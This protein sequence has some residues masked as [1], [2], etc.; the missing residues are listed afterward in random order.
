MRF[1]ATHTAPDGQIHYIDFSLKPVTDAEGRV[2]QL[3]PEGRDI[4]ERKRAEEEI[5]KLNQELEQRVAE[6]TAQLEAAN[7]ELEAFAYSVSHDLRAPLRAHRR[8]SRAAQEEDWRRRSTSRAGTTWHDHRDVGQA[9]GD[10]DRRPA[11]LL[12]HGART[13][14]PSA[15]RPERPGARR[16]SG[17]CEPETRGRTVHWRIGELPVVSGDRAMLRVVL[18]NLISNALKFTQPRAQAEI[19]I[20]CLPRGRTESSSSSCATT[21]WASTCS[22]PTSSSAS[23]SACT[24]ADEFEGTGIGLA[25]VRR[26]INRHGG[27]TW[28][29]GKVD[30]GATFYFRCRSDATELR[31][32]SSQL[33]CILAIAALF[34]KAS[35]I[36]LFTRRAR[37]VLSGDSLESQGR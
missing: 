33:A 29:E 19:E 18:V 26:V 3:I 12:A 37:F 24:G 20:G 1:E 16:S 36:R 7:K 2:V 14:W 27:R 5:R 13:R 30:G 28:A 4:T 23:S 6:R 15:G 35:R 17:N 10:A 11:V 25:N 9:H 8:L 34:A 22:M 21:A 31:R 32:S